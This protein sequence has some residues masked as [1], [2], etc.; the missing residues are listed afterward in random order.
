VIV[1]KGIL[2]A[3]SFCSLKQNENFPP[4]RKTGKSCK[5]AR[6]NNQF[7]I[8]IAHQSGKCFMVDSQ[9][10]KNLKIVFYGLY[11]CLNKQFF[12]APTRQKGTPRTCT[13]NL[14]LY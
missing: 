5:K 3:L 13:K 14:R 7:L 4:L 11:R 10:E 6:E 8:F 12:S 2:K 9:R 1:K